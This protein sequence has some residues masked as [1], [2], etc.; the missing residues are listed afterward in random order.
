MNQQ[1]QKILDRIES[2]HGADQSE[3]K[4]SRLHE[5][6]ESLKTEV[7]NVQTNVQTEMKQKFDF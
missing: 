7:Q 2:K 4:N 3:S 1:N 6:I 5:N